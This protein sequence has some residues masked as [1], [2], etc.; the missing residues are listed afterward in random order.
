VV[1]QLF[2]FTPSE[3]RLGLMLAQGIRLEDAAMQLGIK[4]NT[5]RTHTRRMLDK[6]GV[7]RQ[8]DLVLL[9]NRLP[10]S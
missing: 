8:T 9:L 10:V 3:T 4:V 5:A 2:Q 6:A 1:A 7:R